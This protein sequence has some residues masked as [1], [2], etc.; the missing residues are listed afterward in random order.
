MINTRMLYRFIGQVV[1]KN[2]INMYNSKL[3]DYV[4]PEDVIIHQSKMGF[5]S[6]TKENP[7]DN[8][9]FYNSKN[10]ESKFKIKKEKM[11]YMISDNYQEN[12]LMV[13]I[14]DRSDTALEDTVNT[15]FKTVFY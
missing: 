9:C 12:V 15:A 5:V 13:F 6:G 3:Y 1:T 14:R 11:T 2:K 7:I 10:P 8:L 4:N